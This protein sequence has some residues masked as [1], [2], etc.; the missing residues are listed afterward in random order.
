MDDK[1]AIITEVRAENHDVAVAQ[2]G[3]PHDTDFYSEIIED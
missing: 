3:L 2:S 1:D